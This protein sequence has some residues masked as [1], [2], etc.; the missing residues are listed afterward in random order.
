MPQRDAGGAVEKWIGVCVDI[1]ER[2]E[3]EAQRDRLLVASE[4]ARKE[5]ETAS[6]AKDEFLAMLGHE[7]RNPLGA[8]HNALLASRLDPSS[9][10]RGLEIAWRQVE[11]LRR[12]VDD[13]L[14]VARVS[15]GKIPI[16]SERVRLAAVIEQALDAT[17]P[18]FEAHGHR[19]PTV[20]LPPEAVDVLGD[21][22]RLQQVVANLLNNAAKFTPAGGA[23]EIALE[24]R[25]SD[26]AV[27]VRDAGIGIPADLLGR[28]FDPFVQGESGLDRAQGG[29]GIG[30]T[31]VRR[32]VELHGGSVEAKSEGPG[33]G[34]ELVVRIP[35][36]PPTELAESAEPV[37]AL[38]P[39]SA[40]RA[41]IVED[42]VDAAEALATLLRLLG[43]EVEVR[44]D[45]ASGLE[46]ARRNPPDLVLLD[47]GL[48]G[49]DGYEV[50]SRL[51]A[52]P[53]TKGIRIVALSGYGRHQDRSRSLEAGFDG[54]LVKPIDLET[55]RS[56]LSRPVAATLH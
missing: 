15:E 32:I 28:V 48:P 26:A 29:L 17:R 20:L 52:E 16:R 36:Q 8:V 14:D 4:Q 10:E 38:E 55:L 42:N 33:R 7:L 47:I 31:L 18:V 19:P 45:G 24:R 53:A 40:I 22:A 46:A 3:M 34:T 54:H 21:P 12:L 6:R 5:A 49:M 51:R 13:L 25:G 1:H 35:A 23:I 41:L 2:R 56:V 11:Q 30:L 44:Y 50:A 39:R 37:A 43:H 27:R 9:R